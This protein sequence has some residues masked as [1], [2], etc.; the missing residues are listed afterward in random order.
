MVSFEEIG[1]KCYQMSPETHKGF[2]SFWCHEVH[3]YDF[4]NDKNSLYF[5]SLKYM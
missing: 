1:K 3:Y 2:M 4:P 5:Q